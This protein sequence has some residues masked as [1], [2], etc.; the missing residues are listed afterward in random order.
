MS[1]FMPK[2]YYFDGTYFS[3][4]PMLKPWV[5]KAVLFILGV[6]IGFICVRMLMFLL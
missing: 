2:E 6:I 4:P 1:G 5:M 3:R